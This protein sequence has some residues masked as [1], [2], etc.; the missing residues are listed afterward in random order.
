M[1]KQFHT[2]NEKRKETVDSDLEKS[3]DNQNSKPKL[4]RI[5]SPSTINRNSIAQFRNTLHKKN[6]DEFEIRTNETVSATKWFVLGKVQKNEVSE[7]DIK[8]SEKISSD[9][10]ED[11]IEIKQE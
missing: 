6:Q 2:R 7:E 5:C 4:L 9:E 1:L 10:D 11:D 8:D 3:S